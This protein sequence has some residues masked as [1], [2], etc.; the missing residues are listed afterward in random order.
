MED[1]EDAYRALCRAIQE[2]HEA[3]DQGKIDDMIKGMVYSVQAKG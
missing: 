2:A 1:S 3:L